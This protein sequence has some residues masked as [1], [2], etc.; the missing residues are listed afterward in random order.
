MEAAS[1]FYIC[2]KRR[3]LLMFMQQQ[4]LTLLLIQRIVNVILSQSWHLSLALLHSI[5]DHTY[6]PH[7]VLE[8]LLKHLEFVDILLLNIEDPRHSALSVVVI[9]H[10]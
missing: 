8:V 7:L 5:L 10:H 1:S 6:H 2:D 3:L 4:I 9:R